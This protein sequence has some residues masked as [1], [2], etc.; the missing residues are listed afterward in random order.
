M[1]GA[2]GVLVRTR[3]FFRLLLLEMAARTLWEE[4][5]GWRVVVDFHLLIRRE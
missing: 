4:N 5:Q 2:R 1:R 3:L